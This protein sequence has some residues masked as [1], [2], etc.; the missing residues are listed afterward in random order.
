MVKK[1]HNNPGEK[2]KTIVA[3]H[4][5][6]HPFISWYQCRLS[7]SISGCI[8]IYNCRRPL[9]DVHATQPLSSSASMQYICRRSRDCFGCLS[10]SSCIFCG[11][12]DTH[13]FCLFC[14]FTI[15]HQGAL[16]AWFG[17]ANI[18]RTLSCS[19]GVLRAFLMQHQGRQKK[20]HGVIRSIAEYIY[21][22]IW[23]W[24]S[25]Q[26]ELLP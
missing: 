24:W 6:Y 11:S 25:W 5:V 14:W 10:R 4:S 2:R 15:S 7:F 20:P 1:R 12:D 21:S 13:T 18:T 23:R 3:I 19:L 9:H 22:A 16:W 17:S 8:W 26:W